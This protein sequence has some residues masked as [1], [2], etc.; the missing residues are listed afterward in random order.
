MN[1]IFLDKARLKTLTDSVLIVGIVLLVYNLAT[2]AGGDP[3]KFESELFSNTLVAYINAFII[4]FMYWSLLSVILDI[5]LYLDDTLF[6]LILILL[7]TLTLIPVSNLLFLQSSSQ[8]AAGFIAFTHIA[9]G[10]LLILVMKFKRDRLH[11]LSAA[12]SRYILI[13]LT[14]IPSLYSISFVFYYYNTF[15]S[16]AIALLVIPAF[17][18][19]GRILHK[20]T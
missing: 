8:G 5:T 7:I 17:I 16:N 13:C 19:V 9:P 11:Q 18:V 1:K 6:L 4:V 3:D 15:V 14:I 12:E 2:L 10:L 20:N